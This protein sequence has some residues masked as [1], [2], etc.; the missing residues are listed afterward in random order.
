[1]SRPAAARPDAIRRH[2]LSLVL[3]QVHRDGAVTRAEL[4]QRL[5]LSRSTIGALVADLTERGLVEESVPS[6]GPR[7]GRPSHVVGPHSRGPFVVAAD[8]DVTHVTTAA[9][10]IGGTVLARHVVQTGPLPASAE[11]VVRHIVEAVPILQAMVGRA[12]PPV[13]IGVS[14][15]G[16]VDRHWGTVGV[17]PNMGWRN[18]PFGKLLSELATPHLPVVIGNDADLALLAEHTRGSAR[19]CDDVVMII[20]RVGVGSGIIANGAPL[21]GHDGHAGEIGHNVVD[22]S[23]P[24]C[25]CGNRGCLETYIGDSALLTLAGRDDPPDE[26]Y[27]AAVFADARTGDPVALTAVQQIAESLGRGLASIVNTLNPQRVILGGSLADILDIAGDAVSTALDRYALDAPGLTA[28]LTQPTFGADS[29]LL[30]AA[31]IAFAA[32]LSDPVANRSV[33]AAHSASLR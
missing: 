21:R 24:Q 10:G 25:H 33:T 1:M 31:E 23:G 8:L 30:G 14:V 2:N 27:V 6:G 3:G 17:A 7:A 19:D 26:V 29:A 9:V 4:T 15:P 32:L 18:T 20:G 28:Q 13:A 16:T 5:G 12:E 22:A 11:E